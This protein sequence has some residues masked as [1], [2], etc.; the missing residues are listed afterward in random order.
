VGDDLLSLRDLNRAALARQ[1]LLSRH[2]LSASVALERLLAMQG[3]LARAPFVGLWSRTTHFAPDQLRDAIRQHQVVRATLVRGTL[4]LL[5]AEDLLA[6]RAALRTETELALPGGRRLTLQD[7]EPSLRIARE[8]FHAPASFD[9]LRERID[10]AGL[11]EVRMRAYAARLLL[12]LVQANSDADYGF[13]AGGEF[14]L[15]DTWLGASVT[16]QPDVAGLVR[17]YLAAWGPATPADFA[18]WSGMKGVARWFEA[19]GDEVVTYRDER[20]RTLYD[21]RD[22]PRPGG[23]TPAPARLL[24]E[25]DGVM[26]GWQDRTRMISAD[27]ARL[28][29]NRN[30]QVPAVVL[31]DGFVRGTWKLERTRRAATLTVRA[32]RPLDTRARR[33]VEQEALGLMGTFEPDASASVAFA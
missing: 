20:K 8:H 11:D 14:V 31:V 3:Q 28:I 7:L 5:L 6:F 27:D 32:F 9:S 29:A 21:L 25:F 18:A 12:P 10:A 17:R 33:A 19:L 22:A 30:L 4:H 2:T 15:A 24:P 1:L 23:E 13:D 16:E 26:L